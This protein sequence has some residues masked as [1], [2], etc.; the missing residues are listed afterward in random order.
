[1]RFTT[2]TLEFSLSAEGIDIFSDW[3][4][5]VQTKLRIERRNRMRVRLQ[6]EDIALRMSKH[7]GSDSVATATCDVK[8]GRPRVRVDIAGEPY[9]PLAGL[10]SELGGWESSL[11]TAIGLTPQYTYDAGKNVVRMGLPH[12]S[13]NPVA[14]IAVALAIGAVAGILGHTLIP[15]DTRKT[16]VDVLLQP[17]YN[18]WNRLLNAISGPI[19]FLTVI[20]TMLNT[21]RITERGGNSMLVI[22]RYFAISILL[23]AASLV[24]AR[25]LFPIA[26]A[27][28]TLDQEL[29]YNM[30][31]TLMLVVP[32]NIFDPFV[33]SNTSQLLFIAL[34]LGIILVKLGSRAEDLHRFFRQ[35]NVVGL[36]MAGAVSWLVPIFSGAF[37]CLEL[38]LS[39]P[40]GPVELWQPLLVSLVASLAIMVLALLYASQRL[41]VN[42]FLLVKKLW[43]PFFL[44]LRT[45]SL[46]DSLSEAQASCIGLL[47]INKD[48]VKAGLPQGLVLYMP[49]S[50]VGTIIFTMFVAHLYEVQGN[51]IWYVSAIVMAVVVFVATPPV[52]G[53]NLLAYVVLFSTLGIPDD[54]LLDA[55]IFDIIFGIFAG[56]ANQAMLQLEM[57]TQANRFGLLDK[58]AL[59]RAA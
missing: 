56:A 40:H 54:A 51:S 25:P 38:W 55:M 57:I 27:T 39:R 18:M 34:A 59:R 49:I 1:M 50:A 33:E 23:A 26:R 53:A 47:G 15:A 41:R 8:F 9:N 19:I 24:F 11:C 12:N 32:S 45:G 28:L 37:L 46:D 30:L 4:E 22:V 43:R 29:V 52:P 14:R 10:D 13:M 16:V 31:D 58:E 20:T 2:Q 42:P 6:L 21:R 7:V 17:T 3:L 36:Q 44:A 48:Y 35:A 5:D